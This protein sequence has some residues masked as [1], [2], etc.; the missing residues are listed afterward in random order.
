MT[1]E[2]ENWGEMRLRHL[3]HLDKEFWDRLCGLMVRFKVLP[4]FC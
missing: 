2:A 4:S 3:T 1:K